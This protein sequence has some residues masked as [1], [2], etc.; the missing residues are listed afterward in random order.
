MHNCWRREAEQVIDKLNHLQER[1]GPTPD[2]ATETDPR[3]LLTKTITYLPN[4][5][6]RM[7]YPE[8]RRQ[9][10]QVTTAWMESLVK[11]I[12]Y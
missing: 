1:L 5:Q 6:S 3:K 9:G 2:D 7:D 8:Y 10:L 4:N 11:E 12:N